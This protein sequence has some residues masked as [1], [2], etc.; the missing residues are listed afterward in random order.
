[1]GDHYIVDLNDALSAAKRWGRIG[2]WKYE[3]NRGEQVP[4]GITIDGH[5]LALDVA[6]DWLKRLPPAPGENP[7]G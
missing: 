5:G 6:L 4:C 3:Y 7:N 1:M 2:S